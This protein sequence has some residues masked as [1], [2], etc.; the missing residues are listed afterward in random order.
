MNGEYSY[1]EIQSALT[2]VLRD[3]PNISIK[4]AKRRAK[5]LLDARR[6][7]ENGMKNTI[8]DEQ[9]KEAFD[10]AEWYVASRTIPAAM[11]DYEYCDIVSK[12]LV[13]TCA[14]NAELKKRL[15]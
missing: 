11:R 13:A 2:E 5:E 8:T 4:E 6:H 3:S 1:D 12:A 10:L 15:S 14:E 7:K 9:R